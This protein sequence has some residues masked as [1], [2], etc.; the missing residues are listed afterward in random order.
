M[1]NKESKR[2]E[3]QVGAF[4]EIPLLGGQLTPGIVCVGDT[5]RRPP[6]SNAAFVHDLLLWLEDQEF[7]FAPRFLGIDEQGRDI[8]SYLEGHTWSESG[9][10]LLDDLLVQAARAI[11]HLHD[12][13]AGSPLA[14]GQEIVAHNELGPHNTIFHKD[15]LIGLIDW[16]DAAPGTRLRDLANAVYNYV[17]VGH[18]AN[19]T[20]DEQARRIRLMCAAYGWDDPIAIVNDFEADLQ[21]ALRNHKQAGRTGAV[22]VFEEEVS[23]MRLRAQE[24]RLRLR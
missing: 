19:Q 7:R 5:V 18:W 12:I 21:Q 23:W 11:R 14:Q 8:L 1:L 6:K 4:E 16:D 13:T 22:R 3:T 9:S 20:A 24:L 17:D 2:E 10:G 15:Q